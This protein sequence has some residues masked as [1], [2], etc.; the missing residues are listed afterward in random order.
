[1]SD[2]IVAI[3]FK[4]GY[5]SNMKPAILIVLFL[6]LSVPQSSADSE[7]HSTCPIIAKHLNS[8]SLSDIE[9]PVSDTQIDFDHDG[10]VDVLTS[11]GLG[12]SHSM[13]LGYE[14][15]EG[16][17]HLLGTCGGCASATTDELKIIK[18]DDQLYVLSKQSGRWSF[19]YSLLGEKKREL[20][21]FITE[22]E[23]ELKTDDPVCD[24]FKNGKY[25]KIEF[26][27]VEKKGGFD[28]DN[29]LYDQHENKD[30]K[31]SH[32]ATFL[33]STPTP[34]DINNDGKAENI[35]KVWDVWMGG[36]YVDKKQIL[37]ISDFEARKYDKKSIL[38][39]TLDTLY[40]SLP[41]KQAPHYY[42]QVEPISY[43]GQN[44]LSVYSEYHSFWNIYKIQT[45]KLDIVCESDL[46]VSYLVDG[47]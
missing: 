18:I 21:N 33:E 42:Y 12:T 17:F 8:D 7:I 6:F 16:V 3:V 36:R 20:C 35:V 34:I 11:R 39:E 47:N 45:E 38:N 31:K 9:A 13:G 10:H 2:C 41:F 29:A 14:D 25:K 32:P 27:S 43:K 5:L 1:M 4:F 30:N 28:W 19:S 26:E 40:N 15:K 23:P 46:A 22:Y 24:D 37:E 44:Y